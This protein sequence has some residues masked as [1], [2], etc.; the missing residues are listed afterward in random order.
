MGHVAY[1]RMMPRGPEPRTTG[2]FPQQLPRP[3]RMRH[4]FD[5]IVIGSRQE[6]EEVLDQLYD[7]ISKYDEASVAD[8]YELTGIPS[9]HTDQKWG[10]K[11]LRGSG[12]GR[13]RGGGYLL[14]LPEPIPL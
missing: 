1:D 4:A 8:L 6:A 3:T 10:W 11:E 5:E 12:V 13:V 14:E 7:L 9:A 2:Q